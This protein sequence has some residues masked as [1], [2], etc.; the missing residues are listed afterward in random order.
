MANLYSYVLNIQAKECGRIMHY[1]A[2]KT[3]KNTET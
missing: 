2:D 3:I 1:G